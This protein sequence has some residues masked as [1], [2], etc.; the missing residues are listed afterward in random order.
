LAVGGEEMPQ[1]V[2]AMWADRVR[3]INVYGPSESTVWTMCADGL[4]PNSTPANIGRAFASS[5]SWITDPDNHNRL[6]PIGTVGE[7]LIEGPSLARGYL[8]D[9]ERTN[10]AFVH[11][12]DW[13]PRFRHKWSG[14]GPPC[15]GRMY[16][17][18][19]LVRYHPDGT[20]VFVGRKD[21]Q[22]K[23]RGQRVE[24]GEIEHH[25]RLLSPPGWICS[26]QLLK[27]R[28]RVSEDVLVA[29][30][31][32][33]EQARAAEHHEPEGEGESRGC[34]APTM[35]TLSNSMLPP[36]STLLADVLPT[37]MVPSLYITL[38]Q[39]PVSASGK[40]NR[41]ALRELY[42]GLSTQELQT[43]MGLDTVKEM[44]S[45]RMELKMQSLWADILGIPAEAIGKTDRFFKL[46]GD[47]Y[48]AIRLVGSPSPRCSTSP[49]FTRWRRRQ[50]TN[51]QWT[52]AT[53]RRCLPLLNPFR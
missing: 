9:E 49:R 28:L 52:T 33:Q 12:P 24:L 39:A 45:T 5:I 30:V 25:L 36:L 17:T 38:P 34:E 37:H 53:G 16:K 7:L 14:T 47:S 2:V 4:T 22:V 46:G 27:S 21:S 19:D 13:L 15:P 44:P 32:T 41:T 26:V 35:P 40:I 1:D 11:N 8:N 42:E 3:L 6:A 43:C 29:F 51:T 20:I 10:S 23:I 50:Q 31:C 18:G 48:Y